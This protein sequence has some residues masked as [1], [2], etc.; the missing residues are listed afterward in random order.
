MMDEINVPH[1]SAG[2]VVN[3]E[4][5]VVTQSQATK[6]FYRWM[7]EMT[8]SNNELRVQIQELLDRIIA[9]GL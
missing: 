6:G 5:Q 7:D 1:A 8:R 9:G 4:N 2:V 3:D